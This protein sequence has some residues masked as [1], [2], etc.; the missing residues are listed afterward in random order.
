MFPYPLP[1]SMQFL[2]YNRQRNHIIFSVYHKQK[3]KC[4]ARKLLIKVQAKKIKHDKLYIIL[5]E[6]NKINNNFHDLT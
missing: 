6:L 2:K 5:V 1:Y 4:D 3:G